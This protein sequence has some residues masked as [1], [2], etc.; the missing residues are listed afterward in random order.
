MKLRIEHVEHELIPI[1]DFRETHHLPDTFGIAQ[2]EP[3]NYEGL[4]SL[5]HAGTPMNNLREH[6]LQLIPDTITIQQLMPFLDHIQLQFQTDFFNINNSITLK[7]VEIEFAVAGFGDVL[8]AMIYKMIPAIASK[9]EMPSFDSLYYGWVNNSVRVSHQV[10]EVQHKGKM[11]KIQVIN[12]VYGR[13]GL[14][15][16]IDGHVVYVADGSYLCPADGFM[17]TLLKDVSLK[18]W[19]ALS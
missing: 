9:S 19:S 2:F 4:G 18:I 8:R 10:H 5:D 3:K 6:I 12:H 17:Y 15:I 7:D 13:A 1:Q 14:R 16:D 11:W